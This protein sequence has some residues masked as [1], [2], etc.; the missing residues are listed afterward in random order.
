MDVRGIG[1]MMGVELNC[2]SSKI[3][4][5]CREE[6]LLLAG[7]GSNVIRFVPPLIISELEIDKAINILENAIKNSN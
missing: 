5:L 2:N 4:S 1:L 7:A 6:G 3:I